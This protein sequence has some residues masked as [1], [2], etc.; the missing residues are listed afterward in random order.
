MKLLGCFPVTVLLLGI[1]F[2]ILFFILV[3]TNIASEE[4]DFDT[5]NV[6]IAV[7]SKTSDYSMQADDYEYYPDNVDNC[8]E[9]YQKANYPGGENELYDFIKSNLNYPKRAYENSIEGIVVVFFNIDKLGNVYNINVTE[10]VDKDLDNEA[11]RIVN[12][13]PDFEPA[14]CNG[15][16]IE[17]S[18]SVFVEFKID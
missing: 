6:T 8:N 10:K 16:P 15:E 4:Y 14:M 18:Y 12:L 17:T 2:G 7:D 3:P 5:T 9:T 11:I 13:L 1:L